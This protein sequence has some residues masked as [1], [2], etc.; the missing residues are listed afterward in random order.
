MKR[1]VLAYSGDVDTSLAVSWLADRSRVE[2]VTVT[3]DLGGHAELAGIRDRALAQGAARAHVL[4]VRERFASGFILPVLQAGAVWGRPTLAR[5]LGQACIAKHLLEIARIEGAS[6][7]AH[8]S[9]DRAAP[10]DALLASLDS[11]IEVLAPVRV[12]GLTPAE[13]SSLARSRGIPIPAS[14]DRHAGGNLLGRIAACAVEDPWQDAPDDLYTLTRS[15]LLAP[16]EPA[17]VELSFERGVPV[18]INDAPMPLVELIQ[19][20]DTIAGAHG[21]GRSDRVWHSGRPAS[22]EIVEAPAATGLDAAHRALQAFVT[23]PDLERLA[24]DLSARY[25][26]LVEQ[27]RWYT[28]ARE[29]IDALVA[30]VQERVTGTVR[31]VFFKGSCRVVGRR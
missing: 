12:W 4:D 11:Q 19:S 17:L 5:P 7:V 10:L 9:A 2:V 15:P 25:A 6:L 30:K 31:L 29:A 18:R 16:D 23:P 27:G 20:L 21:V 1:A 14:A 24:A 13:K 28:P 8:G 22:C 26:D 3:L